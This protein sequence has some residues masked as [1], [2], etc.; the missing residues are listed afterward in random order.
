MILISWICN[1]IGYYSS[2]TL[3]CIPC[4]EGFYCVTPYTAKVAC[5]TGLYCP[6]GSSAPMPCPAG[7]YCQ[8]GATS[9][10][11]CPSNT[12][13]ATNA[14][15]C[16]SCISGTFSK[17]NATVCAACAAGS[18]S[19]VNATVCTA[20]AAGSFSGTNASSCTQCQDSFYCPTGTATPQPCA[21]GSYCATPSSQVTCLPGYYCPASSVSQQPCAAGSY[22][23]TP[24]S[25]TT[26]DTGYYCPLQTVTPQQCDSGYYCPSS[27]VT[28][29]PCAAGSYC[30]TPSSQVTCDT[31]YYCPLQTVTQQLCAA[32]SYCSTPSSQQTIC[33]A[34]TFSVAGSTY[35]SAC[36]SGST[37]I[38]GASACTVSAGYYD[39]GQSLQ[40]YYTFDSSNML[41]DASDTLGALIPSLTSPTSQASGPWNGG[42]CCN[43]ARFT[44]AGATQSSDA[45]AQA[46]QLPSFT[47][48]TSSQYSVCVWY[49]ANTTGAGAS[50]KDKYLFD[51]STGCPHNDTVA[52]RYNY[53]Q[54]K[55][56]YEQYSAGAVHRS[57]LQGGYD[58]QWHHLCAVVAAS[59]IF[60]SQ[61]NITTIPIAFNNTLQPLQHASNY[62]GR[63]ACAA[64]GLW[65][66]AVDEVRLYARALTAAE[67]A[68]IYAYRGQMTTDV[69]PVACPTGTFSNTAGVSACT[70]CPAGS[71]C[72][73]AST[74]PIACSLTSYCPAGSTASSTCAA[75]FYCSNASISQACVAGQFCLSGSTNYTICPAGYYCPSVSSDKVAC[76]IGQYSLLTNQISNAT[77]QSC[78]NWQYCASISVA[79][80][81]CTNAPSVGSY[82]TYYSTNSSTMCQWACS[83]GFYLNGTSTCTACPS[84]TWCFANN[85]TACP[86]NTY[87]A[88][89]SSA[90]S[91]CLCSPGTYGYGVNSSCSLCPS[92]NWCPG[93]NTNN[94]TSCPTNST[95]QQSSS[96]LSQCQCK[97]GYQGPNGTACSLCP[98]NTICASG[99]L[100]L[101][102]NNSQSAAGTSSICT[103]VPGYYSLISG[104]TCIQCPV[105]SY[106]AG[107][108]SQIACTANATTSLGAWS[109]LACTC[110][111]G[112]FGVN[113]TA[114]QTCQANS[115][116]T[117]DGGTVGCGVNSV[118]NAGST[119]VANCQ[120]NPGYTGNNGLCT[121][122]LAGFYKSSVGGA[123][124]QQCPAL[125][126]T[127]TT[128]TATC[129]PT[130]ICADGQYPNP[131]ANATNDNVCV[132]CPANFQCQA[133]NKTACPTGSI[134]SAGAV[135]YTWCYCPPGMTGNVT[136]PTQA[137]C[138]PCPIGSF[139]PGQS[140]QC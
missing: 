72:P 54:S 84:N 36:G 37:S 126:F 91:S 5:T 10:I 41:T 56:E 7:S 63:S 71:Y 24:S 102:G 127:G 65:Y 136:S 124:C 135:S 120:C 51:S 116:C 105:G 39:L 50:A 119:S 67:I 115:Y 31:G 42:T 78:K 43:S 20:C 106:C 132:T 108:T 73:I 33:S 107:D 32:G 117:G 38:S 70:T 19:G 62:I 131:A 35:C 138:V 52:V 103:C 89:Q 57:Q 61:D 30:T 95:S 45:N 100:S 112:F 133:N 53:A 13:S 111:A 121:F 87:S 22:C 2:S 59:S 18:F 75:G 129:T 128:A 83:P 92:G 69:L 66:G 123:A 8:S 79:P 23:A 130:R 58:G 14:S 74:A 109:S 55:L 26:C 15:A 48:P 46:F 9:P 4:Q 110:I 64:D 114:C 76:S 99:T 25:Q 68:A 82:Y 81:N 11:Q 137:A 21:A 88:A 125:T 3:G 34:N 113:N 16:T 104:G 101:C 80:V 47:V 12:Y 1:N 139:C 6:A 86:T 85:K 122:C 93:G 40:A 44:Q 17:A 27:T 118:S 60:F 97:P 28:Q 98:P 140:C 49:Q 134:S 94:V 29:Q 96:S 90:A 77:C